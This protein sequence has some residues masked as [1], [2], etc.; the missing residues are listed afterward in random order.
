MLPK[1]HI[2]LGLIASLGIL[3][4]FPEIGFFYALIIFL[5][6]FL[7]DFDH[8]LYYLLVKKDFSLKNAFSWFIEKRN[9]VMSLP[10]NQRLKYKKIIMIFH[11]LECWIL[12]ALL[13]FVHKIFLFILIGI[14]IHMIFDL[15]EL[16]RTK[17]PLY[18]KLSQLYVYFRN[19]STH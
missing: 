18:Y 13:I 5:S 15:I 14:G 11:G 4:I 10:L 17:F 9:F 2:I 8:Y 12:L 7:I 6:S 3:A 1:T 19:K 16:Y